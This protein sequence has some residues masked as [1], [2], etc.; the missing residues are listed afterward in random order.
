MI[1]VNLIP[2]AL[3]GPTCLMNRNAAAPDLPRRLVRYFAHRYS[4]QDTA[5][6]VR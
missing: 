3:S 2:P 4:F 1:S 6:L 5:G